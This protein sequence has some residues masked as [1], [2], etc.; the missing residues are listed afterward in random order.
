MTAQALPDP[1]TT[2]IYADRSTSSPSRAERLNA[3][4]TPPTITFQDHHAVTPS[5]CSP[6]DRRDPPPRRSTTS[7]QSAPPTASHHPSLPSGPPIFRVL[8]GPPEPP[9]NEWAYKQNRQPNTDR[10]QSKAK[11]GSKQARSHVERGRPNPERPDR[12]PAKQRKY[13][14]MKLHC[15]K[16]SFQDHPPKKERKRPPRK[17]SEDPKTDS[18]QP[19]KARP[20]FPHQSP[21]TRLEEM[22]KKP[23]EQA[24]R[25]PSPP[26][27]NET[28]MPIQITTAEVESLLEDLFEF[29]KE[30][31]HQQTISLTNK[32]PEP[33]TTSATNTDNSPVDEDS[34]E[35]A[36]PAITTIDFDQLIDDSWATFHTQLQNKPRDQMTDLECNWITLDTIDN[37]EAAELFLPPLYD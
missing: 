27:T 25:T 16:R 26:V 7:R 14:A 6:T 36:L 30:Q 3:L 1:Q 2:G 11:N 4:N 21:L 34:D 31:D 20:E 29:A 5:L 37:A 9:R 28:D 35:L 10:D 33:E 8:S 18:Q 23:N 19:R 13:N 17:H 24:E 15:N 12:P 22:G 32:P